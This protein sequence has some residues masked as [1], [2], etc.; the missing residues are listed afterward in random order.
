MNER[1][2][3]TV[4]ELAALCGALVEG[5]GERP[6]LGPAALSEAGQDRISFLANPRYR[7]QLEHTHAGA[8][9]VGKDVRPVRG[10]LTLLR[11]ADP[12]RAFS[13]IIEAFQQ[14]EPR[15][16]PGVHP[17]AVVDPG[18]VLAPGVSI[19]PACVVEAGARIGSGAVLR[20]Q[21]FVGADCEV[22]EDTYLHPGVVLGARVRV[23]KR[24]LLHPGVVVGSDGFGFD[25]EPG[26]DGLR[27]VK[28]PQCG[29]V[30]IGDDVEIGANTSLDRARF[31][32]TRIGS[33]SKIDNLVQ[34]AHNV[35]VDRDVLL[36]SQVGIAG[37]SRIGRGAILAGQVGV[38]GHVT[39]APGARVGAQS[40]VQHDLP[41]AGDYFG[42]PARPLKESARDLE[43]GKRIRALKARLAEL[44]ARIA[45]LEGEGGD[46]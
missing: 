45:R 14:P 15:P 11:V 6:I 17:S 40:G 9:V 39:I 30:E 24:C 28:V 7:E 8:V 38:A 34:I 21:V 19:G 5:D 41:A 3:R 46:P 26:A 36:I 31:G 42:S 13:R 43:P 16:A 10:D 2:T 1:P 32:A 4:S 12:N 20:A 25:P 44:E 33:G 23:G 22:G 37:S 29:T 27:W 18:A 35:V